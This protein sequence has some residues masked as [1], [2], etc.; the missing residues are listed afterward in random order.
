MNLEHLC[1][2]FVWRSSVDPR[3]SMEDLDFPVRR[4]AEIILQLK[5]KHIQWYPNQVVI[6]Q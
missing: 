1:L 3:L 5:G 6:P 4:E 2:G